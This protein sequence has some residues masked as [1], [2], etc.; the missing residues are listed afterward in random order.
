MKY[1]L[2]LPLLAFV[3]SL[4]AQTSIVDF[5]EDSPGVPD[6]ISTAEW[7]GDPNAPVVT[8][9]SN[10]DNTSINTTPNCV[11]YVETNGS[12]PGNS[13]QFAFNGTTS[14]T[15]HNLVTNKF[16]KIMVY[17][18]DKT[19]FDILLELGTGGTPNFSMTRSV[20]T[21][22]N[23]WTEVEFDFSGAD[24]DA[25]I[26]NSSG[27]NSNIRFH[28]NNG[29]AGAGDTYYVDEY[30]ITPTST[31]VPLPNPPTSIVDY[32][33]DG[34]VPPK[35]DC[36]STPEWVNDPNAPLVTTITNPST[37]GTNSTANCVEYVETTGSSA[38]NSLQLTFDATTARSGH[39]LISDK[40]VNVMVYSK[41][42]TDFDLLLELGAGGTPHYSM[43]KSISTTLN[44]WTEVEFDFSG[45][46]PAAII[47]NANGWISNVRFHFNEGSTGIG[48]TYLVD[49]YY[50]AETSTIGNVLDTPA[51]LATTTPIT[52]GYNAP[53][54]LQRFN[55]QLTT[56]GNYANFTL[57]AG[58]TIIVDNLDL[59]SAGTFDFETIIKYPQSG[60]VQ[61]KLIATG[62]DI[63]VQSFS[64]TDYIGVSYPEFSNV[65]S[66]A[67]IVDDRSLKY[68]GPTIG[69]IDNDGDY[70]LVLNNHN[71]S[72]SK[73]YWNDGDETFT[74]LV[75]DLA[76]W[77]QMDLHGAA[78]GD[79][80][81]DGDLD[82]LMTIGGGNGANPV[83]PILYRNDDGVLARVEI[84]AGILSSARGRSPRWADLDLDGD[85][86]L[87]LINAAGING[88]G[89]A[90]HVFYENNGDA[91]FQVKSIPGLENASGEK[92]LI[93]DFN[94]DCID[95]AVILSPLSLWQGNGDFTFT[96]VS[97]AWLG[98]LAGNY[99]TTGAVDID[100][101]NDGDLDLY[102][103]KG[104]YYFVVADNNAADFF[105]L[106][107]KLDLR[108]S[109]SQGTLP[110]EVTATSSI[111]LTQLDKL[112][113]NAYNGGLPI[114]L[115][116]A[117]TSHTLAYE[118]SLVITQAMANGFPSSRTN[119]GVYIGHVGG[120][121]WKVETVR[122]TDIYWSIDFTLEDVDS[123]TPDG[124]VPN[125]RNVQDLLLENNNG[126]FTD[127]STS[128][129]IPKGGNHW[130]VTKGDFNN[131]TYEDLYVY[132]YGYIKDRS[133]DYMLLNNGSGSFDI[134]TSHGASNVGAENHG[135][136]GQAIDFN[137]DGKVDIFSGDDEYG[138]WHMYKNTHVNSNNYISVNVGYSPTTSV[139]AI[140]AVVTVI[141]PT[142]TFKKRVGSAGETHSQ[143]L[144][145]I[146]H[147]GLA[148]DTQVDSI[149]T[150]WRDGSMDTLV[151]QAVNQ[152]VITGTYCDLTVN[153][154]VHNNSYGTLKS[155][156]EC[157]VDGDTIYIQSVIANMTIDVA[158]D[159]IVIDKSITIVADPN[160]NI[161]VSSNSGVSSFIINAGK[162]VS[163]IGFDI[164][165]VS[166]VSGVIENHGTLTIE[167]MDVVA[168]LGSI[169]V[170]N[171]TGAILHVEG[172]CK[173][174]EN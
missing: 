71:D 10:P 136:M 84:A 157:A 131:D 42:Q 110:F 115:G 162:T 28:F 59:P 57:M 86:D 159:S 48:D 137:N 101:D 102:L 160:D 16:V 7:P 107:K 164:E 174:Q 99:G 47:N 81:N 45:A 27:W 40:F 167:D 153:K 39:D 20:S 31:V 67:G 144:L 88:G 30:Y 65:S 154:I 68:G 44:T 58:S 12:S 124:W 78:A 13:L 112:T 38:G 46:D 149:I 158:T 123:F 148:A 143:S 138:L 74:V 18:E 139:D 119:N 51:S 89:G 152:T 161:K 73:L 155:A 106:D 120:G 116:T 109:G 76:L 3:F 14:K 134:T 125:N 96:D 55:V 168:G 145:N 37:S 62:S 63:T 133:S 122:N 91:T 141:T 52:V 132:R 151:N 104:E 6:C 172:D 72:P 32:E 173:L 169:S 156:I 24:P 5:E 21:T 77:D 43:T 113:R 130:G 49:E 135:D 108:T 50:I 146:I 66:S 95:D 35:P 8:E 163:L 142:N 83:P 17:S 103:A 87:M 100:I 127:V 36:I 41:D 11:K 150:K 171:Q 19:D 56:T 61:L 90:Q 23:T 33:D 166:T 98:G 114:F 4:N 1:I 117:Q 111:K 82:L 9:V 85:L 126:T 121:V 105:P 170:K 15:G 94:N 60:N 2:I 70:D 92:L 165:N 29:T 34:L 26:D 93:T 25:T 129:N 75:P 79:Y 22:L 64:L 128:W 69:D 53:N 97:S 80:D 140:S 118:D 147:F 54:S